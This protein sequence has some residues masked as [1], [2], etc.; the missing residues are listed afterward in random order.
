MILAAVTFTLAST[1]FKANTTMPI[2]T[3]YSQCGGPNTSPELHWKGAP[4]GTRSFAIVAH[5]PD[6]P[7][8]GGWYHWVV[9]NLPASTHQLVEGAA[10]PANEQGKSSFGSAGYGGPCPPPGKVH[11]YNFTIYA[12]N[13]STLRGGDFDGPALERAVKSHTIAKTTLTGLYETH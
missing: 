2:R 10:L 11:H 12:L 6:A 7:A 9:Y 8:P 13:V 3:V 1:T 4:K 5:D